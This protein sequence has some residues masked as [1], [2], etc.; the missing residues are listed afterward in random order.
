[1]YTIL[2]FTSLE[3]NMS[4][5]I[6]VLERKLYA[7]LGAGTFALAPHPACWHEICFSL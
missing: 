6:Y 4:H 7:R 3:S 2:T 5:A 1:V